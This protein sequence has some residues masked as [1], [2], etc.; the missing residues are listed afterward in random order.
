[1]THAISGEKTMRKSKSLD[2]MI[3]KDSICDGKV[4]GKAMGAIPTIKKTPTFSDKYL[5]DT[6]SNGYEG[7]QDMKAEQPEAVWYPRTKK[8]RKE[9]TKA[10]VWEK[11]Q[12]S[13]T[14]KW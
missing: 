7:R 2:Q 13:K 3:L 12:M 1:M 5:N 9:E 6:G 14:R 4:P 11:E 8:S 10:E